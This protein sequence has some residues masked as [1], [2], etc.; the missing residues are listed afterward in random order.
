MN[1]EIEIGEKFLP[2]GTVVM[3]KGGTKR[4]MITGFCSVAQEDT[5]KMYDYS[6]CV[7]PE[8]YI[9]SNQ[10]CLFDHSQIEKVYF[11]G[12]VDDEETAFKA[13]LN[14]LLKQVDVNSII[15]ETPAETP[16]A[17]AQD[18]PSMPEVTAAPVDVPVMPAEVPVAPVDVPAAPVA[19]VPMAPVDVPAAPVMP[20][21]VPMAPVDVAAAP[22]MPA[23][24]PVA[25]VDVPAAPVAEVPVAPVTDI[26]VAPVDPNGQNM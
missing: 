2:I 10:V 13:K 18:V 23:E 15:N 24:V 3:L 25:P 11:K 6:G 17:V 9:S 7:Y 14:A 8:G 19:E 1:T 20:A 12:L 26:P 16:A 21:E 22:V 5:S 4:A